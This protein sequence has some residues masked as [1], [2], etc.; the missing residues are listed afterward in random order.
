[1][2]DKEGYA[3]SLKYYKVDYVPIKALCI[4]N[5]PMSCFLHIREL[6]ELENGVEFHGAMPKSVLY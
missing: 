4:T 5:M 6:V 3:A 1:M 2:I